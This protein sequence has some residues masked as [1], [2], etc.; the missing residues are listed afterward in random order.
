MKKSLSF[1][2]LCILLQPL[3]GQDW[4]LTGNAGTNPATH[5]LGTTDNQLLTFR[6]NN[7]QAGLIDGYSNTFFGSSAGLNNVPNV[8]LFQGQ[9]NTAVGAGALRENTTGKLNTALG[10]GALMVNSSGTAN[11]ALGAS[12][13]DHC[14]SGG[15]NTAIGYNA[16]S[17]CTGSSNTALG[18]GALAV[19]GG[20]SGNVALGAGALNQNVGGSRGVAIGFWSMFY[21][22]NMSSAFTNQNVAIGYE[23]LRGSTT[24]ANNYGNRNVAVGYQGLMA[25]TSGDDN[26]AVGNN[27]LA[28]NTSGGGNTTLGAWA[29]DENTT[30][31]NNSALGYL[32]LTGNSTGSTN[33][34]IGPSALS[35]NKAGSRAVAIGA[36]AMR[37]ANGTSTAFNNLNVAVGYQ[38]MHGSISLTANTGNRNAAL[39]YQALKDYTTGNDNTALGTQALSVATTGSANTAVGYLALG[40]LSTGSNNTGVGR[41]ANVSSGTLTNATAL[42]YNSTVNAS[43][44]V[45]LGNSSVTVVEGQVAYTSPSDARFKREVEEDVPGLDLIMDLRPVSYSFDRLA[46]AKH[47]KEN[48]EGREA[49]L[50]QA[51]SQR[52]VGFLAQEVE[53]VVKDA[54]YAAF[55]V[56]HVPEGPTD[57]YGLAYAQFVVPLV[58]AVQELHAENEELK[59]EL[60]AMRTILSERLTE[61]EKQQGV[62]HA[63]GDLRVFPVP[64]R[65]KVSIEMEERL[66][67]KPAAL[68]LLDATGKVVHQLAITALGTGLQFQLPTDLPTGSYTVVLYA[69]GEAPRSARVVITH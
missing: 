20:V 47:V 39:G 30:G 66:V 28:S 68:E 64:T 7:V 3:F 27:S 5:F 21:A 51:S 42:G 61:L 40:S 14:L 65:D 53:Q 12:A 29:L 60:T 49:E 33:V 58:K 50:A 52:T 9:N 1:F 62:D 67:G 11:T 44:K 15:S 8:M 10:S 57:N 54:K 23:A 18:D 22:N 34:A 63:S 55:D 24:P 59:E 31:M 25:N 26:T 56:V 17:S 46:F 45:R 43:N 19:S 16:L 13:L 41:L 32:A 2:A 37:Y 69:V 35:A 4:S 38:A 6:R 48:V 36:D